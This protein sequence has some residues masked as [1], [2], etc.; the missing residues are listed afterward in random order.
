M[1][2]LRT[3]IVFVESPQYI[4]SACLQAMV[5]ADV[6]APLSDNSTIKQEQI[7]AV[8]GVFVGGKDDSQPN[9]IS[10]STAQDPGAL[11]RPE[12]IYF[13]AAFFNAE[14][15]AKI[16]L[17]N[18]LD[19]YECTSTLAESSTKKP[20]IAWVNYV[21]YGGISYQISNAQYKKDYAL[22]LG[23]T[24]V[25]PATP[26]FSNLADWKAAMA[27]VDIVI[28]ETYL[29]TMEIF[30]DNFD[31]LPT[32]N[33]KFIKNGQVWKAD[34]LQSALGAHDW[35]ESAIPNA[36]AVLQDLMTIY[37][38]DVPIKHDRIWFR[39]IFKGESI[40]VEGAETCVNY[41]ETP[42]SRATA[43]TLPDS[44]PA[45]VTTPFIFL[46]ISLVVLA[47]FA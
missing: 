31:L 27:D 30:Y 40:V 42:I 21:T 15:N 5:V 47:L 32:S 41:L 2:G 18:I 38:P 7:D 24:P 11:H 23:C 25:A 28:D 4:N 39:N 13:I 16:I 44:S 6:V 35:F 14:A 9:F 22:S 19:R 17:D 33:F 1:L 34:R 45:S 8:G 3:K 37:K 29:S 26:S 36:D 20:K 10:V 43:C 12:W 46:V